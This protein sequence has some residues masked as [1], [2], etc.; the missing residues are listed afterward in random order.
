[1]NPFLQNISTMKNSI[2]IL[3]AISVLLSFAAGNAQ[4]QNF[5][6]DSVQI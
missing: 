4:T 6:T 5:K 3:M 2:N 1:M